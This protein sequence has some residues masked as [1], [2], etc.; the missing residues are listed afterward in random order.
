MSHPQRSRAVCL[1]GNKHCCGLRF[2]QGAVLGASVVFWLAMLWMWVISSSD[3]SAY[4][5]VRTHVHEI[6]SDSWLNVIFGE[7]IP[8]GACSYALVFCAAYIAPRAKITVAIVFAAAVLS[9]VTLASVVQI[10]DHNW[11][12]LVG[13]VSYLVGGI[14]AAVS[15]TTGKQ[16]VG[17]RKDTLAGLE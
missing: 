15:I 10:R 8:N 11:F 12:G 17:Q 7:I 1:P 3:Y 4:D 16:D 2:S 14:I 5:Y 9:I 6:G 13:V